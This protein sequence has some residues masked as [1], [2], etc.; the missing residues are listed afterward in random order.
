MRSPSSFFCLSISRMRWVV[1]SRTPSRRSLVSLDSLSPRFLS[2][3]DM[4]LYTSYTCKSMEPAR[5]DAASA[6]R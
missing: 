2:I 3:E 5:E 1:T 6:P 4:E